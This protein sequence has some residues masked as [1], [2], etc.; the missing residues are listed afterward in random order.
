MFW[1]MPLPNKGADI[2]SLKRGLSHESA[3]WWKPLSAHCSWQRMSHGLHQRLWETT[4]ASCDL[5]CK[6]RPLISTTTMPTERAGVSTPSF[7]LYNFGAE[8]TKYTVT[9]FLIDVSSS[10]GS[11]CTGGKMT[12]LECALQFVKLKVQEMV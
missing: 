1:A 11:I 10:M 3:A 12:H 6:S 9:M 8:S 2:W 5:I 4:P 7:N